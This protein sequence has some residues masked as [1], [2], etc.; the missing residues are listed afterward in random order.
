MNIAPR[1]VIS[2]APLAHDSWEVTFKPTPDADLQ[3]CPVIAW[4]TVVAATDGSG[5]I[6]TAVLPAFV[7]GGQVW[8]EHDLAE[9]SPEFTAYDL[10]PP[11]GFGA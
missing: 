2:L 5:T 3:R 6:Q 1:N 8:T 7:W 11:V 4:A 10:R 9:H